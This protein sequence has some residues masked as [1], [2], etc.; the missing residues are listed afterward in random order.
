MM[1]TPNNLVR[2]GTR[3][4]SCPDPIARPP[5]KPPELTDKI[6]GPRQDIDANSNVD[7]EEN[8]PHKEGIISEMYISPDQSYIEKPQES[9]DI[10]DTSKLVQRYLP[11][12]Q[13]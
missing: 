3:C 6:T 11:N 1:K 13:T 5:P 4:V 10:V 2:P 12:K 7:F 9:I 8:S